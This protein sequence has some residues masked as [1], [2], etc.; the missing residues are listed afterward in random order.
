MKLSNDTII[1]LIKTG[2]RLTG[3]VPKYPC[4]TQAVECCIK[5]VTEAFA[6]VCGTLERDGFIRT[7]ISS[8]NEI[9]KFDTKDFTT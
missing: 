9:P 7:R 4:Y 8:R 2:D 6:S 5:L 3:I 1:N